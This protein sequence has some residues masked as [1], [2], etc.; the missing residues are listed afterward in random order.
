MSWRGLSKSR[1]GWL[2]GAAVLFLIAIAAIANA[3]QS[4]PAPETNTQTRQPP[5]NTT[6]R[7]EPAGQEGSEGFPQPR[8]AGL[9]PG[10]PLAV[11]GVFAQA[12]INRPTSGNAVAQE[13]STL[14]ALLG[15]SWRRG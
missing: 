3:G 7:S 2:L 15:A 9:S 4:E 14:L 8:H 6:T 1:R 11:A 10:A 13:R 12:W 5:E